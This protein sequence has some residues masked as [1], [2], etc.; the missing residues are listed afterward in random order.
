MNDENKQLLGDAIANVMDKTG[1]TKVVETAA[2]AVGVKDCGCKKRQQQLND[3][4][5]RVTNK[6]A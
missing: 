5:T 4:Q 3:L 1:V 6:F 2:N